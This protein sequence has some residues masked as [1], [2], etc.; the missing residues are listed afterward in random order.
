MECYFPE[1]MSERNLRI[2]QLIKPHL[3]TFDSATSEN[4]QRAF[5]SNLC[6]ELNEPNHP[7]SK[8]L[9]S[10]PSIS[11]DFLGVI[12]REAIL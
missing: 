4:E 10:L 1:Y 8:Y 5:A 11:P 2:H 6:T 9:N 12:K 3:D 7:I